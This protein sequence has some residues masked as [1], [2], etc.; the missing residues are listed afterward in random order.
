MRDSYR[1]CKQACFSTNI[2]DFDFVEPCKFYSSNR[3]EDANIYIFQSLRKQRASA[4]TVPVGTYY[5]YVVL[6]LLSPSLLYA[7]DRVFRNPPTVE[8]NELALS[9]A[10][11][12]DGKVLASGTSEGNIQLW[13]VASG[14]IA[15]TLKGHSNSVN[16]VA[17]S[18]DGKVLASASGDSTIRLWDI[19]TARNTTTLNGHTSYVQ[20][21]AFS[22]DGKR[23]VSGGADN[24]VRIWSLTTGKNPLVLRG[25]ADWVMT[26]AFDPSGKGV[27][28]GS[29]DKTVRLWDAQTGKNRATFTEHSKGVRSVAYLP[30]G[31]RLASASPD[32]SI[33]IRDIATGKNIR[34][35]S[36]V[37]D[38]IEFMATSPDGKTLAAGSHTTGAT[39]LW[40]TDSGRRMATLRGTGLPIFSV[41][42]SADSGTVAV[43][44]LDG[45]I[46][47]WDV[48]KALGGKH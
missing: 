18:S 39:V 15:A 20:A 9:L 23:L 6:L 13:D 27:A 21:L 41:S 3:F 11:S 47:L 14:K 38:E 25:H 24:T 28:S 35:I 1:P 29:V 44:V 8:R 19:Q 5:S 16:C 7:Q 45:T 17:F 46:A 22:L 37:S 30:D 43:G 12:P 40:D 31:Q 32:N 26:V 36:G 33:R 4:M 34:A 42:F 10:F 48:P 2:V